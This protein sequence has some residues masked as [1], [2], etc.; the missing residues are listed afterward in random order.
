VAILNDPFRGGT[1]LPD[2][3]AVSGV[4]LHRQK[5]AS[6][7]VA[8]RAHH[9]DV[10]GMSPGS[11]PMARE[12]LPGR[13]SDS[14]HPAGARRPDRPRLAAADSRQRAYAGGARR[15]LRAQLMANSRGDRR[16]REDRGQV[17]RGG[18]APEHARASGLQ[19]ADDA[20]GH[21]PTAS[22]RFSLH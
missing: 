15:R 16:L 4:F 10:G 6:F 19:R 13:D 3:T 12:M 9:A 21:P 17:W 11:M 8:S 2:I 18:S 20:G 7:Y 14:T 22:R 1:H 5:R